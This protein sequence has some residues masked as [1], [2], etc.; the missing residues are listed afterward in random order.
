MYK[1]LENTQTTLV[2]AYKR[3]LWDQIIPRSHTLI[4]PYITNSGLLFRTDQAWTPVSS[5]FEKQK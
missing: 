1:Q 4:Q 3:C 2:L 5:H